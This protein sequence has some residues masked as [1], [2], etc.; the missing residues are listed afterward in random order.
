V[1]S[2]PNMPKLFRYYYNA[3]RPETAIR[4]TDIW[5]KSGHNISSP[6]WT[7]LLRPTPSHPD[8]PSTH[9]TFGGAAAAVLRAYNSGD[10][11][12]ITVSSNVT[13]DSRGVITRTYTNLT[14]ASLENAASRIFGG[15]SSTIRFLPL[16]LSV[17]HIAHLLTAS[18]QI[19]FRFAGSAGIALGDRVAKKTLE[20]FDDNWEKF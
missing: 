1:E 5:L 20:L 12:Q 15:V 19:H 10:K 4:R 3:W 17:V 9:A 7:P 16:N 11:V 13:L 6:N 18:N 2:S 14:E 8:Y